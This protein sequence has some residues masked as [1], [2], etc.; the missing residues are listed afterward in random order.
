[1]PTSQA[2]LARPF[3]DFYL[4]DHFLPLTKCE[5]FDRDLNLDDV[6]KELKPF[7]SRETNRFG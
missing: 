4:D 5:S 7:Y 6:S 3:F 1:L 2:I